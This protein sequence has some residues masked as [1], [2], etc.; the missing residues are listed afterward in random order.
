MPSVMSRATDVDRR[1]EP[2]TVLYY[3]EHEVDGGRAADWL[4]LSAPS[5]AALGWAASETLAHPDALPLGLQESRPTYGSASLTP[6]VEALLSE[7]CARGI[8]IPRP[9]EVRGYLLRFPDIVGVVRAAAMA[10]WAR[11][12][13]KAQLSLEL[14][15][16]PEIAHEYLTLYAR[17]QHYDDSILEMIDEVSADHEEA[18]T[19]TAGWLLVTTDFGPPI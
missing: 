16:D 9:A 15:R 3:Q 11:L 10:A 6:A 7:V 18:L 8:R 12:G 14:Y 5:S 2:A 1:G 13:T 4:A 19:G 17:Q